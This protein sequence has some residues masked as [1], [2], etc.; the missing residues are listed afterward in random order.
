MKL[1]RK[2]SSNDSRLVFRWQAKGEIFKRQTSM[3]KRRKRSYKSF[4]S[5][6]TFPTSN[7]IKYEKIKN[8]V[9]TNKMRELSFKL[10]LHVFFIFR[11]LH[12][13]SFH[14]SHLIWMLNV[15]LLCLYDFMTF[16]A[17]HIW[18]KVGALGRKSFFLTAPHIAFLRFVSVFCL[19]LLLCRFNL[20][21]L[22][23]Q[24]MWGLI[25]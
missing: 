8:K 20:M 14:A 6:N 4:N 11:L 17:H 24:A 21:R 22:Q 13:V 1:S 2:T 19:P 12:C 7:W 16:F 10:L 3:R 5:I 25:T 9:G 23:Q 15:C 18:R